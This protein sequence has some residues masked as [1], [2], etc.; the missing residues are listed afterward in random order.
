VIELQFS[1]LVGSVLFLIIWLILFWLRKDLRQQ[2]LFVS[3]IFLI[4]GPFV[5]FVYTIDW[6]KP[7]TITGT[8]IGIEDFIFAFSIAGIASV[9][10]E[11]FFKKKTKSKKKKENIKSFILLLGLAA[12]LFFGTFYAFKIHSF[13]SSIISLFV[14]TL[15]ILWQRSD[16]IKDSLFSGIL[17]VLLSIVC[18]SIIDIFMPAVIQNFWYFHNLSGI[19]I[20]SAPLED[21]VWFFFVGMFIGPLYE[22]WK[23]IFYTQG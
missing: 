13:Y 12:V 21:V 14:P 8:L 10:Y 19:M 7:L 15:V 5:Q 22:Y 4:I 16:L 20:L 6:W 1:Y 2:M 17:M 9:I 11:E 23:N 3:I 18:F